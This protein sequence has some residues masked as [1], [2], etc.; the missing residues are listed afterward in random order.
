MNLPPK[1]DLIRKALDWLPWA[2]GIVMSALV[3]MN[4]LGARTETTTERLD[5]HMSN[6]TIEHLKFDVE[7]DKHRVSLEDFQKLQK[8]QIIGECLENDRKQLAI[9]ELLPTCQKYGIQR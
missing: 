8:A 3:L 6:T 2:V 4:W 7:I 5:K 9:Q 1:A